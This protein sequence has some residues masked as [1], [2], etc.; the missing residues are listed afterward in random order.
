[1][2]CIWKT[3]WVCRRI[4][5]RGVGAGEL[6]RNIGG[7]SSLFTRVHYLWEMGQHGSTLGRGSY[8]QIRVSER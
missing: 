1:M 2:K 3:A 4:A 6:E 8:G 7:R 5:G